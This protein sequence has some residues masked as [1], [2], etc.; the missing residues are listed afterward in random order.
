VHRR[1]QG[2]L[3]IDRDFW[4]KGG[5]PSKLKTKVRPSMSER[6]I[7]LFSR[8]YIYIYI[9]IYISR[10]ILGTSRAGAGVGWGP[11]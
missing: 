4:S 3:S 7:L 1:Y 2:D 8:I 9:Y 10:A 11:L 6:A 5:R